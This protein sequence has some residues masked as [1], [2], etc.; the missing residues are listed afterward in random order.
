MLYLV[1]MAVLKISVLLLF[2]R[3]FS[4]KRGA[5]LAIRIAIGLVTTFSLAIV[6]LYVFGCRPTTSLWSPYPGTRCS[7]QANV[8]LGTA[9][10]NLASNFLTLVIPLPLIWRLQTTKKQRLRA[11]AVLALGSLYVCPGSISV[12]TKSSS[13]KHVSRVQGLQHVWVPAVGSS[14]VEPERR[15][16]LY[17][18][19]LLPRIVS[20][21][22]FPPTQPRFL[23]PAGP[24]LPTPPF[25]LYMRYP[26]TDASPA[27]WN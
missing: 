12:F 20:S 25:L 2:Y 14:A 9:V 16:D 18:V 13:A 3:L 1:A 10:L 15:H 5:R 8:L 22:V 7:G 26:A 24:T 19:P 23:V 21:A 6:F 27:S 17:L 4:V 11:M